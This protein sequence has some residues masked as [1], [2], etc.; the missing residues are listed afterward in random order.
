M[1][2]I[3]S[4]PSGPGRSWPSI[5]ASLG[6]AGGACRAGNMSVLLVWGGIALSEGEGMRVGAWLKEADLQRSVAC[7]V[8]LA[9]ELVHAV[10]S[11][12][13]VAVRVDVHAC[14]RAGSLAVEGYAEGDRLRCSSREHEVGVTR[15]EPEGDASIGLVEYD[16]LRPGRPLAGKGPMAEAQALRDRVEAIAIQ[17]RARR[18]AVL[19]AARGAEVGLGRPEVLPVGRRF[20]A[21]SFDRYE[22]ALHAEQL[23][24]A[25][26]ELLVASFAEMVVADDAVPV[27]EVQRRPVVVG[28]GAPDLVVVVDRDG[29]VDGSLLRRAAHAVDVVLEGELRGVD[30]DDDQPV[31]AV[32]V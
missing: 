32:S 11:E 18:R 15:V 19:A 21:G 28:E 3:S 31:V 25:A 20:H 30:D 1:G 6:R 8:V 17:R 16:V 22:L 4:S 7:D 13:A 14:R 29:I 23:L 12:Y 27:G 24:D 10:V 9:H 2:S 26:L 5:Q